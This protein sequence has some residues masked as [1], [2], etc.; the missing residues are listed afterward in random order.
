MRSTR[1]YPWWRW[2]ARAVGGGGASALQRLSP[3]LQS[4]PDPSRLTRG[5]PA[6]LHFG[7]L[8]RG[9]MRSAGARGTQR[10]ARTW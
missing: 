6:T 1:L 3:E 4:Q 2:Q 10:S 8:T 9:S 7:P 5:A